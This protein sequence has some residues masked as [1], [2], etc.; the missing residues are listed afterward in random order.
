MTTNQ[1]SGAIPFEEVSPFSSGQCTFKQ[2]S[3]DNSICVQLN[4]C[5][6]ANYSAGLA[7]ENFWITQE[8]NITGG[9]LKLIFNRPGVSKDFHLAEVYNDLQNNGVV[10]QIEQIDMR[11]CNNLWQTDYGSGSSCNLDIIYSGIAFNQLRNIIHWASLL[12]QRS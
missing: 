5:V 10:G 3:A 7:G 2:C 11:A 4:T 1:D 9:Y 8:D 12:N 6:S